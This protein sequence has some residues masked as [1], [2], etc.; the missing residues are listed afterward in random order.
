MNTIFDSYETIPLSEN[1]I[2]QFHQ[3]LLRHVKKDAHHRG[4]YKKLSNTVAAFDR[5]GKEI[6]IVFE[7]ETPFNTSTQ[8]EKLVAWTRQNLEERFYHPLIVIGVFVVIFLAIH[9]FQDG[10]GRL[11]RALTTMLLLKSGYTYVPYSSLEA[12]IEQNKDAY[13]RA[14]NRSQRTLKGG[15]DYE[16]WLVF[17]L[18][19]L[20]K[21]KRRLETKLASILPKTPADDRTLSRL[22][23]KILALFDKHSELTVQEIVQ[24]LDSN[25]NTVKKAV[26]TL[27]DKGFIV[28]HGTTRGAWYV[29]VGG[30]L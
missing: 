16:W 19:A 12:V 25:T 21:Q 2:K 29:R 18:T 26:K 6:G 10:N 22:A 17:F 7:T 5:T 8:M 15:A 23:A 9:P 3:I 30:L 4:A 13:Y 11:S 27:V 28:K 1:Y 24:T 20:Q 14:L